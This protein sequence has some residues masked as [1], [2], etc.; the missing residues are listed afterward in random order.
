MLWD[1]RVCCLRVVTDKPTPPVKSVPENPIAGIN[2]DYSGLR[3]VKEPV[4][5]V[6]CLLPEECTLRNQFVSS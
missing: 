6:V 2:K 1:P 3:I 4:A 5:E